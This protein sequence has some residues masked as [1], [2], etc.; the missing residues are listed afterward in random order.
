MRSTKFICV[1]VYLIILT[2]FVGYSQNITA[3]VTV[4]KSPSKD[5]LL[6]GLTYHGIGNL[7]IVDNDLTPVFYRKVTGTIFDFKY[8][9][10][11]ELTYNI[12]SVGSFGMDSSGTL[13]NR[14]I[15]PS[16]YALNVHDLQVLEDSSYYILGK[17]NIAIDMS[18]YVVNGKTNALINSHILFQMDSNNNEIW[19]WRAFDHYDILDVDDHINL[20]QAQIDWTHCNAIE[21]D[22]DGN[23][24]LSTRNF[25]EITKI[26]RQTGDIIWRLGGKKNQFR[27]V[28]DTLGFRRQH[29]VRRRSNGNLMMF[30]NG[31]YRLPQF[32]SYVEYKLNE[33]SLTATLVRRYSRNE[34][35]Y[36]ASRGSVQE[37]P[38]EH[39][40]IS[41]GENQN[42]CVTEF[43]A[44]DSIEF[45]IKFSTP[46]HQYRAYRFPWKTNYFY[47]SKDSLNFDTVYVG[48]LSYQKFWIINT[49]HDTTII[50][51]FYL[52]DSAF[53]VT[54]RL[55]I[56][57]PK[58]D[59]V[60]I[61]VRFRPN[62]PGYF[63]DK[64][65][66]RYVNDTLLLGKQVDLYGTSN[67]ILSNVKEDYTINGY[68]LLQNYPNPFNPLTK[69]KY[70]IASPKLLTDKT[71]VGAS[72][73][74]LV[75]LKVYDILGNNLATLVNKKQH[76]GSYEVVFDGTNLPSGIYFCRLKA[77][78]FVKTKKM[79]LLK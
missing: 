16:G 6:L 69:I 13:V 41:W 59:S 20:T 48:N 76:A 67:S 77:G 60:K 23:I 78:K 7:L 54:N 46:T 44:E 63:Y 33:D 62:H 61:A 49:R 75:Q 30:D 11:S 74:K 32:S 64:L 26:D 56:Y 2:E 1:T 29:A 79:V 21:I 42:P 31:H 37:L 53:L 22:T 38:N 68:S 27:F 65:N 17:E 72:F 9:P 57:L 24:L 51:Q 14:F 36:S 40:L 71:F 52:K 5:Y 34:S 45:E 35:V 12:Y 4:N 15:T 25:D 73:T 70:T 28:D 18:Q 19:S 10:N 58:N 50:N 43:N 3:V 39:T 55:P 66:I 8:Q 47:V